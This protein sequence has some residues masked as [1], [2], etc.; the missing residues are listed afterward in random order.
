MSNLVS[1]L[2]KAAVL[3]L[4]ITTVGTGIVALSTT[5]AEAQWRRNN[6]GAAVAAGI[7]G[8]IAAGAL[9][10]GA[11]RAHAAPS[12]GYGYAQPSY[13]YA[14]PSYGYAQ[15]AYSY[16]QPSYGHGYYQPAYSEG[17]GQQQ[18]CFTRKVRQVIDY[19]TVVIRRVRQCH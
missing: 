19:D 7:I 12:Y 3:G 5:E 14:Q 11:A 6:R 2:K 15:P 4:A 17:Y 10:A 1:R 18:R 8:G 9:I 13:G 16:A